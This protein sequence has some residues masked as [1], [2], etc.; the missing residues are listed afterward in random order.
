MQ[1]TYGALFVVS[2][3]LV[4]L[5]FLLV[6]K[7]QNEPYLLVFF[8]SLTLV[9]LGYTLIAVSSTVEMALL[10]NKVAYLGQVVLPFC[11]FM[12]ISRLCGFALKKWV[13]GL[14][15]GLAAVMFF[16]V[17]TAGYLDWYYVSA[18][19]EKV[20]GATVLKKEYGPLHCTNLIYVVLYFVGMIATLILSLRIHK[21]ASQKHAAIM[22]TIVLGNIA[23]WCVQKV[24]PWEF[25]LLSVTY[26]MSGGAFLAVWCMLQ[27]YVHK[28]DIPNYTPAEKERLC[29]E[30][31][32]LSMEDKL[33][34]V[35]AVVK[36]DEPLAIRERQILELIL[37]NKRRREIA[38]QLHLSENTV[39]TYTRTLYSKL[40]VSCREDLYALLLNG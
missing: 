32:S 29:V 28:R 30:I 33:A 27:D 18:T 37:G 2:L 1:Y 13:V 3:V 7:K 31:T 8:I 4:A 17:A 23:M 6:H 26:L 12:L 16:I 14:L 35:L 25:E 40:G 38:E 22:L 9:N 15:I 19:I 20:A 24:I 34:R 5:Y 11:M 21:G 36:D 10:A 39:K